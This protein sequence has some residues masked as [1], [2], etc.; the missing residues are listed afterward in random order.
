M[1][2]EGLVLTLKHFVIKHQV[3]AG[4]T[5]CFLVILILKVKARVR[6]EQAL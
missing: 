4:F 3:I 5:K 6:T 1:Q 2:N